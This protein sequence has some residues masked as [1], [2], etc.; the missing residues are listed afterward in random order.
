MRLVDRQAV[1]RLDA[2]AVP[3]VELQPFRRPCARCR[4]VVFLQPLHEARALRI[5]DEDEIRCV[6]VIFERFDPLQAVEPFPDL[7]LER[8]RE[9]LTVR[10]RSI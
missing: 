3:A 5:R 2:A 4:V 7:R 10:E 9:C 6:Y 8:L 1:L